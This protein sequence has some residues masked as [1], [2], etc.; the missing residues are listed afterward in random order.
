MNNK[1]SF[2]LNIVL[3]L[4]VAVLYYLHFSNCGETCNSQQASDSTQ[5]EKPIVLMPKDIKNSKVVYVNIDAV[6]EKYE[7]LKD[8]SKDVLSQQQKLE[9]T[10]QAKAQKLQQEYEEMQ[11]KASQGLLSEN[12]SLAAQKDLMTK[13]EDLDKMEYQLQALMEK[14]QK[15]N[16][17]I[18]QTIID[19]LKGYNK[20]SQYDYI[21]TYTD[22][23]GGFILIANDSMDIT[24][25]VLAGLNANYK[26][27]KK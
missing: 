21:L 5:T 9:S 1:L 20:N 13:K 16:E 3:L 25:E 26:K 27:N 6:N 11:Q 22:Q 19:Y 10:Y 14:T 12:Q 4:A 18:R 15:K 17:E 2:S 23:P 24:N 7:M 8:F